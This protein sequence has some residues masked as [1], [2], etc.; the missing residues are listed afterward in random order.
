MEIIE[1]VKTRVRIDVTH[2]SEQF[3]YACQSDAVADS[4]AEQE[5][6]IVQAFGIDGRKV[7]SVVAYDNVYAVNAFD[8][9]VDVFGIRIA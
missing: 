5:S 2:V 8:V 9:V 6:E 1:V 3:F 4:L 7:P